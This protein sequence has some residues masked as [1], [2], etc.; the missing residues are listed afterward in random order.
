[1]KIP[2]GFTLIELMITVVIVGILA[3]IAVPAYTSHIV[4][5]KIAEV[6]EALGEGKVRMEQNFNSLRSYYSPDGATCP[7]LAALFSDSAFSVAVTCTG[8]T[9]TLTATGLSAKSMSGYTYTIDQSGSKT[10]KTPAVSAAASCWLKSK[11]QT[12]C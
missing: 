1:M 8:T 9:F 7:D 12:A 10:S 5:S 11:E 6:T 3:S 2:R 4:R